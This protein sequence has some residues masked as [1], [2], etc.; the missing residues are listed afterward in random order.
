MATLP[1]RLLRWTLNIPHLRARL[2]FPFLNQ[3]LSHY[4]LNR[5]SMMTSSIWSALNA[6]LRINWGATE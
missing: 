5:P 2:L 6:A 3:M 4:C 1:Y